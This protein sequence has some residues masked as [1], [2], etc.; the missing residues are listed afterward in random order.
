MESASIWDSPSIIF[1]GIALL[2]CLALGIGGWSMRLAC[3]CCGVEEIG[4]V[5][6]VLIS[7][8]CG[9]AATGGSFGVARMSSAPS[10]WLAILVPLSAAVIAIAVLVRRSPFRAFGIYILHSIISTV[11]VVAIGIPLALA[12]LFMVPA[13]V[14][15]ELSLS[16]TGSADQKRR[17]AG[18]TAIG[19]P[20]GDPAATPESEAP[21]RESSL[22]LTPGSS[23]PAALG[24]EPAG[25]DAAAAAELERVLYQP[26]PAASRDAN[27]R[28]VAPAGEPLRTVMPPRVERNP[29]AQ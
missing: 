24:S 6:A 2:A 4:F 5:Y 9:I 23:A 13:D 8:A 3:R 29:F 10:P 25:M 12:A 18:L 14:W 20:S 11:A 22:S 27:S 7:I 1:I 16:V 15:E 19:Q 28:Q 26:S 17:I 21:D